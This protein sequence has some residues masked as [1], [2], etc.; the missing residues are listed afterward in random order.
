[1][2]IGFTFR[3]A[4]ERWHEFYLLAGTA[5]VTLLGLLFVAVSLHLEVIVRDDAAHLR[6]VAADAFANFVFVLLVSLTMLKPEASSRPTGVLLAA[7]GLLRLALMVRTG[8]TLRSLEGHGYERRHLAFGSLPS[9]VSY[10]MLLIAGIGLMRRAP[11]WPLDLM[12][13]V[14]ALLLIAFASVIAASKRTRRSMTPPPRSMGLAGGTGVSPF[15]SVGA[16]E[17]RRQSSPATLDS[18]R[19]CCSVGPPISVIGVVSSSNS[20][21]G[22]SVGTFKV[23]AIGGGTASSP[24]DAWSADSPGRATR[25]PGI[26]RPSRIAVSS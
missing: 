16:A 23:R 25:S 24:G 15:W 20:A 9:F 13:L 10:L 12:E 8:R 17:G 19:V 6:A 2:E 21:M 11:D 18:A 14:M 4:L 22:Y 1:M 7:L 5:A 26:R 3:A